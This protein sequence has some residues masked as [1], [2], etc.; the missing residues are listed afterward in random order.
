MSGSLASVHPEFYLLCNSELGLGLGID[1]DK[2]YHGCRI[3]VIYNDY[4][5][6][7]I[8]DTTSF[9]NSDTKTEQHFVLTIK[10]EESMILYLKNVIEQ[11]G[12]CTFMNVI[13]GNGDETILLKFNVRTLDM[14]EEFVVKYMEQF[15][16]FIKDTII[17]NPKTTSDIKLPLCCSHTTIFPTRLECRT[18]PKFTLPT[19]P[20]DKKIYE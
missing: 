5:E 8:K 18:F 12:R 10:S 2:I 6:V 9:L 4:F 3:K 1:D 13:K 16:H 7:D 20:C 17:V 19:V 15:I 14:D 11:F